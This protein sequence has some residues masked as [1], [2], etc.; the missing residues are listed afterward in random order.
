MSLLETEPKAT[1]GAA[2]PRKRTLLR[3]HPKL[4][5]ILG[6]LLLGI[7]L[8]SA[9]SGSKTAPKTV[10]PPPTTLSAHGTVVPIAQ[11]TVGTIGGGVV[12]SLAVKVG[13]T[14]N[15]HQLIAEVSSPTQ[16]ETLVAPWGGT[17]IGLAVN[18]GDTL[19]PGAAVA[20]IADLSGYQVQTTDVDEY[21]I[22][23]IHPNQQVAMTVEALDG[24]R[25]DGAVDTVALAQQTSGA[26]VV[27]YPIVI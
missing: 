24:R 16:T 8:W 3:S 11:A 1:T 27:N 5:A 20:T 26:G 2:A 17:V 19:L 15:D 13:Q 14:V 6:V 4:L 12:R 18:R 7:A 23:Q 22:G 25:L 10:A 21:L 9:M